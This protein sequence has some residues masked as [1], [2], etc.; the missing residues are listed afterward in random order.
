MLVC[1]QGPFVRGLRNKLKV[2]WCVRKWV[3][4]R[5]RNTFSVRIE[6]LPVRIAQKVHG[7]SWC[8]DLERYCQCHYRRG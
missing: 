3:I 8:I 5:A 2:Y 1:A 4:Y 7:Q 6:P